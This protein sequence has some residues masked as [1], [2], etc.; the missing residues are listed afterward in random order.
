[1]KMNLALQCIIF[2]NGGGANI[3]NIICAI[4]IVNDGSH[5]PSSNTY[6]PISVVKTSSD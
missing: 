2:K 3:I 5:G 6:S 1:M 4:F